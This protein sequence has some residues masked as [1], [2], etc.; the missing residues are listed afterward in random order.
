MK[1]GLRIMR[2]LLIINLLLTIIW[3]SI[4]LIKIDKIKRLLNRMSK[5]ELISNKDET[6]RLARMVYK[7]STYHLF[8]MRC[9]EKAIVTGIICRLHNLE[10]DVC[11]GVSRYPF[12]SH[13]WVQV[14]GIPILNAES[15]LSKFKIIMM[16]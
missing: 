13:A 15:Y 5:R 7:S 8:S 9:I 2:D 16:C 10:L 12:A 6:K 1:D 14:D 4:R 3:I 11:I